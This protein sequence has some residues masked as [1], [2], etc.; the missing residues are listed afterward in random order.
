[1]VEVTV[2]GCVHAVMY[3]VRVSSGS[4]AFKVPES[5]RAKVAAGKLGRK[6]GEGFWKWDG[7][8]LAA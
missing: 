5:L 4:A 6:T 7:D 1:M 2:C 3:V 8:K